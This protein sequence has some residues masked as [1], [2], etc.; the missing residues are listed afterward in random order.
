MT[1]P[2]KYRFTITVEGVPREGTITDYD[3][4]SRPYSTLSDCIA[5]LKQFTQDAIDEIDQWDYDDDPKVVNVE[6][7]KIE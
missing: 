3:G 5:D 2:K 1:K 7:E 6:A 4:I